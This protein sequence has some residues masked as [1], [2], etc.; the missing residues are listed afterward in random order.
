[1]VDVRDDAEVSNELRVHFP[2]YRFILLPGFPVNGRIRIACVTASAGL[3]A[4]VERHMQRKN[5]AV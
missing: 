5:R 1:V 2:L 3:L 4:A